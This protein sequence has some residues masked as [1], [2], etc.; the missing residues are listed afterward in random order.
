MTWQCSCDTVNEPGAAFCEMCGKQRA[1]GLPRNERV[2]WGEHP[3]KDQAPRSKYG[4][5]PAWSPPTPH[6]ATMAHPTGN[7]ATRWVI[8]PDIQ[9]QLDAI[10]AR[11][12]KTPSGRAVDPEMERRFLENLAKRKAGG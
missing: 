9:A 1:G 4:L 6:I 11:C 10:K 8:P 7:E 3:Q 5:T 12:V 2:G